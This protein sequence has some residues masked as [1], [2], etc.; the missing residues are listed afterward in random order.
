MPVKAREHIQRLNLH[1]DCSKEFV[2][3]KNGNLNLGNPID[4][5]RRGEMNSSVEGKEHS[6]LDNMKIIA[7]SSLQTGPG[8]SIYEKKGAFNVAVRPK[9]SA[10]ASQYCR[11]SKNYQNANRYSFTRQAKRQTSKCFELQPDYRD[12][13]CISDGK[14]SVTRTKV[15]RQ[16]SQGSNQGILHF[17]AQKHCEKTMEVL[18]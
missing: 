11:S 3:S 14:S 16:D 4:S 6:L 2:R 17:P 8:K 9:S 1:T 5:R 13:N 7:Q 18:K 15:R 10:P 12:E